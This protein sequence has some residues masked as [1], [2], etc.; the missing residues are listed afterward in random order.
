M[1]VRLILLAALVPALASAQPKK[2]EDAKAFVA[3]V[4]VELKKLLVQSSTAEWIRS[5]YITDDT[6]RNAAHFSERYL[7]YR[8]QATRDASRHARQKKLDA[9]T[10]RQLYLLRTFNQDLVAP[11][12]AKK[13]E[14]LAGIATK[15]A[16][17]YGKGKGC[18][19]DGKGPCKPLLE[20]EDVMAQSRDWNALLDTW[21]G[22][23]NVGRPMRPLYQRFAELGNEG[24]RGIGFADLGEAWRARYDMSPADLEKE[25]ERLWQ[26]VKPLYTDLHCKVRSDLAKAYGNDKVAAGKPIPAH[27]LGNMWAQ[28]WS[29]IYPLVEPYKGQPSLDIEKVMI[30]KKWDA[31]KMT[32]I[33]EDFFV[34]LGLEKLPKT[35]WERSMLTKPADREVECHASAWD[36][37]Y[38]GDLRIKMCI[39]PR[40]EDLVTIHHE[41]GHIYYYVY[42]HKLPI[43]YQDGAHDG[44]HEAIGDA[45]A[46]SITPGYLQKLGLLSQ[47]PKD[48]KG[49]IN[50]QM[51][52]ALDKVAFLPF[53]RS[54]DQWR[55]DVF[56][57]K[58]KPADYNKTWW[59]LRQKYQGIAP[60]VPRTEEDFDAGAKYHVPGNTPYLR[61]FLARI[62]QFQFHRALCRAAD[63]K[64]PLHECSI[65]GSKAAGDKLRAMLALGSSKPWPE[66]LEAMTGERQMDAGALLE[67]F[68]PLHAWLKEQN[69]GQTCGW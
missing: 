62:L 19:R 30:A 8:A 6:E 25:T 9:E 49:L 43:L 64:G 34:S 61:Y 26:Q 67:Y 16:G 36:V 38:D 53:S 48:E 44:F 23:H 55:W 42:Y 29:Y 65:Y 51:K 45:L 52:S 33:G 17:M 5:T 50:V 58:I 66:A 37:V 10:A 68:A 12:D 13:R 20:L 18:G 32:Q 57:G 2:K 7:E 54:L 27:I 35:F 14:E 11:S 46:L 3:R 41:L 56:G 31:V 60:A 22:W 47:V 69:K 1:K 21:I 24:A 39:R 63:F 59:E 28:E 15:M 4:N 40:E